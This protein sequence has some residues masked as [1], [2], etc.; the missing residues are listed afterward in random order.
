MRR[1][2]W[3]RGTCL[4]TLLAS[5]AESIRAFGGEDAATPA[6]VKEPDGRSSKRLWT[7]YYELPGEK[8]IGR[9]LASAWVSPVDDVVAVGRELV[10]TCLATSNECEVKE[11]PTDNVLLGVWGRSVRDIYAVGGEDLVMRSDG[12]DWRVVNSQGRRVGPH[13][14]MTLLHKVGPFLPNEIVAFGPAHAIKETPE[15]WAELTKQERK[16][17]WDVWGGLEPR[18]T[19]CGSQTPARIADLQGKQWIICN[20]RRVFWFDGSSFEAHGRTPK[21]CLESALDSIFWRGELFVSCNGR[22]FRNSGSHWLAEATPAF[23]RRFAA[24]PSC[25]YATGNWTVMRRCEGRNARTDVDRGEAG[26]D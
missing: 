5:G 17:V 7:Q 23:V 24:G 11:L 22:V 9:W 18:V 1:A 4:I 6:S 25:L 21:V 19:P 8:R 20:D 26:Q 13:G 14:V 16:A 12:R 10:V 3:L 15:G 2:L